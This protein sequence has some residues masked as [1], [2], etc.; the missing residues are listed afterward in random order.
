MIEGTFVII[1]V[2][3]VLYGIRGLI[4]NSL[5]SGDAA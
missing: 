5:E 1:G 4:L 3:L 2:S